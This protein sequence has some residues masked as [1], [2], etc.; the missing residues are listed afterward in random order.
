MN[1]F[2]GVYIRNLEDNDK[3]WIQKN[4]FWVVYF[5]TRWYDRI[6][7]VYLIRHKRLDWQLI[8]IA[9]LFIYIDLLCDLNQWHVIS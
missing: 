4:A 3:N 1:N 8:M 7:Q 5:F 6:V 2:C 9:I